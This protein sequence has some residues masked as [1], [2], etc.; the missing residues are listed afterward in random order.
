MRSKEINSLCIDVGNGRFKCVHLSFEKLPLDMVE[1][2]IVFDN[3]ELFESIWDRCCE[4]LDTTN[5]TTFNDIYEHV[6]KL[7]ITGCKDLLH[8]LYAKSFTYSDIDVKCLADARN[9]SV[10]LTKL[11]SAMHRCYHSLISSLPDSKF[12][13]PQAVSNIKIYQDFA[14][15]SEDANNNNEQISAVQLCMELK[16]LLR[17]RGD[18][19][20]VKDLGN[21]VSI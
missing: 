19:S 12:W 7:T 4:K 16:E 14:R 15:C 6:W 5:I 18:F 2:F 10:H 3:S 13:I 1:Y 21:Q 20:I 17:L 9:I 8:K 11:Y